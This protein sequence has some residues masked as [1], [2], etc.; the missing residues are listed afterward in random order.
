MPVVSGDVVRFAL[1]LNTFVVPSTRYQGPTSLMR[2]IASVFESESHAFQIPPSPAAVAVTAHSLSAPSRPLVG[3]APAAL[4]SPLYALR[5][6]KI[7]FTEPGP[8]GTPPSLVGVPPSPPSP[9]GEWSQELIAGG[10]FQFF[11]AK[12]RSAEQLA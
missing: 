4:R 3:L 11:D 7:R 10:M 9:V 8:G 6:A 2:S 1:L 12:V 5:V